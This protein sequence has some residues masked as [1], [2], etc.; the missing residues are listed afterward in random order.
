MSYTKR[1]A[2][3][4]GPHPRP[5]RAL[6][7]ARGP[8]RSSRPSAPRAPH[9]SSRTLSVPFPL[10]SGAHAHLVVLA[11]LRQLD[12]AAVV[13]R[14]DGPLEHDAL[15]RQPARGHGAVLLAHAPRVEPA[16]HAAVSGLSG[17]GRTT[18]ETSSEFE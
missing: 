11:P 15:G 13:L 10:A 12:R 5:R 4:D 8:A 9:S 7:P 14:L 18:H 2:A 17:G 16:R 3:V 6:T 1:P